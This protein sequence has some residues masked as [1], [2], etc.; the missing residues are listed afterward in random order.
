V[1][2]TALKKFARGDMGLTRT[3]WGGYVGMSVVIAVIGGTIATFFE[4]ASLPVVV[5]ALAW[6]V[7]A[8][9]AVVAAAGNNGPRSIWG[10]IASIY[11]VVAAAWALISIGILFFS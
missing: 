10:W 8:S 1:E 4:S 11:V 3:F 7:L 6:A 9:W 5:I 2:L